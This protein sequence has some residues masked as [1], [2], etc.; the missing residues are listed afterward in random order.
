MVALYAACISQHE[1][2]LINSLYSQVWRRM[3]K[4][5]VTFDKYHY[6]L[7][8]KAVQTCGV[9]SEPLPTSKAHL[10]GTKAPL[11]LPSPE[12]P[13]TSTALAH[14]STPTMNI[15]NPRTDLES[16]LDAHPVETAEER[17][18]L[19]GGMQSLLSHM[20]KDGA[21]PD[22]KTFT[23]LMHCLPSTIEAEN[24]LLAAMDWHKVP[25]DTSFCNLLIRR[26]NLRKN[27][28]QAKV[29]VALIHYLHYSYE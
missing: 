8:L 29:S 24:E 12:G 16:V 23:Q 17:L 4:R 2:C 10:S 13:S 27:P 22:I 28:E 25:L 14:L 1:P 9:A 6:N 11:S 20:S 15:L 7:L 3:R 18:A 19:I 26:R 5:R 21:S